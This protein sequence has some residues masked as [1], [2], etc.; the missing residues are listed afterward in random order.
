M[1]VQ[2]A[3]ETRELRRLCEDVEAASDLP[4]ETIRALKAVLANF[5]AAGNLFEALLASGVAPQA[6]GPYSIPLGDRHLL[7]VVSNDPRHPGQDPRR[8]TR[9]RILSLK[10]G[11]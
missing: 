8:A 9:V 10:E 11:S 7:K 6:E 1:A 2:L 5:L 4:V 3:F